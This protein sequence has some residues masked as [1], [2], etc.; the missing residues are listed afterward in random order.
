M[1]CSSLKSKRQDREHQNWGE[2]WITYYFSVFGRLTTPSNPYKCW[3]SNQQKGCHFFGNNP[4]FFCF[5]VET[6]AQQQKRKRWCKRY[7]K[8]WSE[9][10]FRGPQKLCLTGA[11][12]LLDEVV[13]NHFKEADAIITK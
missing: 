5:F 11:M 10:K 1:W 12:A 2:I 13:N 7:S 8:R 9:T 3:V 4:V 6:T